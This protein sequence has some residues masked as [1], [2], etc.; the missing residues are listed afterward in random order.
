MRRPKILASCVLGDPA[1]RRTWSGTPFRIVE[2][3]GEAGIEVVPKSTLLAPR[4]KKFAR[5][6]DSLL[7]QGHGI[8]P[9]IVQRVLSSQ[10][11]SY[12]AKSRGCDAALHFGTYDLPLSQSD[13]PRYLYVDNN[14][15]LWARGASAARTLTSGQLSRFRKLEH[16]A[17]RSV[18]HVFT[19]GEHVAESFVREFD[20]PDSRVTAVGSGIGDIIPY[21]GEKNYQNGK[22]LTV[23][24]E[25]AVDKG[26]PLLLEAFRRASMVKK[27]L[28]LTVVGGE[29]FSKELNAPGVRFTGWLERG[30]L[31][32]IFDEAALFILPARY[33]PWGLSYLEA[34]AC[35]TPIVGLPGYAFPELSGNGRYGFPLLENSAETLSKLIINALSSAETLRRMGLAGQEYCLSKYSWRTVVSK[36]VDIM[37]IKNSGIQ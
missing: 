12:S 15:E 8:M 33:E 9:G 21:A 28:T 22:L 17:V 11:A 32:Q 5:L 24:K 35:K 4:R 7:G 37:N 36:M 1:E 27:N 31:Q 23:V 3:L 19:V 25:R 13:V 2:A 10:I 20:L 26:L 18:E 34:L 30:E 14:F 16:R 29:K 6:G